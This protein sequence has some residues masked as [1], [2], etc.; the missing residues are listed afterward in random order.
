M[1]RTR[2]TP[3]QMIEEQE[4]RLAKLKEKAAL[5]AATKSPDLGLRS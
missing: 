1:T 4:A 5:D 3:Q 2:R